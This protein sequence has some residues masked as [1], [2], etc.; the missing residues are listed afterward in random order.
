[1]EKIEAVNANENKSTGIIAGV[2][3]IIIVILVQTI[4]TVPVAIPLSVVA[5]LFAVFGFFKGIF[6][7]SAGSVVIN[8]IAFV[9]TSASLYATLLMVAL[10]TSVSA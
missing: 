9:I 7:K 4:A 8:I 2:I 6:R 10:I 1:M 5:V 3:A